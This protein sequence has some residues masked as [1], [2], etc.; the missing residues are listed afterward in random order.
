MSEDLKKY[1]RFPKKEAKLKDVHN[2]LEEKSMI[3]S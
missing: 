1:H 3:L 2:S